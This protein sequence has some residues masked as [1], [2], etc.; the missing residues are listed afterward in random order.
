MENRQKWRCW[1]N[2]VCW[3]QLPRWTNHLRQQWVKIVW[4]P[5]S[6]LA[7]NPGSCGPS[8][9]GL[10]WWPNDANQPGCLHFSKGELKTPEL[11]GLF[12]TSLTNNLAWAKAANSSA[13]NTVWGALA[14]S[15]LQD[16]DDDSILP[17][18]TAATLMPTS[19]W[20]LFLLKQSNMLN[21]CCR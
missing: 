21:F 14:S 11:T 4:T 12:W 7:A 18:N 8:W 3:Q 16:R 9:T 1:Q 2:W 10:E 5:F 6:P 13:N 20:V 15:T 17:Q 19:W